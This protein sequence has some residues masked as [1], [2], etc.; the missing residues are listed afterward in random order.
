MLSGDSRF[1]LTLRQEGPLRHL[2]RFPERLNR[3]GDSHGD[4]NRIQDSYWE[5]GQ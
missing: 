4:A 5:K 1:R 3:W 2:E